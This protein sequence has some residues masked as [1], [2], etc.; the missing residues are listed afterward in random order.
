M[1]GQPG[2][3]CRLNHA[4]LSASITSSFF[5]LGCIDQPT[6]WRLGICYYR[7]T[8]EVLQAM[9][10]EAYAVDIDELDHEDLWRRFEMLASKRLQEA[11]TIGRLGEAV[12]ARL[13]KQYDTVLDI[14]GMPVAGTA[15]VK[16]RHVR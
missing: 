16:P 6:I 1:E 5:I 10:Q 3:G 4:I 13:A 8:R 14:L 12:K 2:A 11:S 7:K 9:G 15:R